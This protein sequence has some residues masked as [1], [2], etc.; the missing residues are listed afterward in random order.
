MKLFTSSLLLGVV[1]S[2]ALARTPLPTDVAELVRQLGSE[3][4]QE[5]EKASRL[6][7]ALPVD[8]PPPELLAALKSSEPEVRDRATKAVQAIR[9]RAVEKQLPRGQ[10]FAKR[11]EID[12]FVA[13]TATWDLKANDERLWLPPFEIG[14]KVVVKADMVG[15][16]NGC[17]VWFK[18][19]PTYRSLHNPR[20]VRTDGLYSRPSRDA[21]DKAIFICPEAI[22]A[23]G[24]ADPWALSALAVV[25]GSVGAKT[26]ISQSLLLTTGDVTS[27][28]DIHRTIV[29]CDG[30]V[31][32]TGNVGKCLIIARG[33]ITVG[34]FADA[35][36]LISGGPITITKPLEQV[37]KGFENVVN[38]KESNP[39]GFITFFELRRIGLDVKAADGAVRVAALTAGN[40]CEKAGLKVGDAIVEVNG[41]K[42]TDA[43]SLRRLLRDAL[44]V[45]EATVKLQRGKDTITAKLSLPD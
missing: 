40:V 2:L 14:V 39:L 45:G 31:N 10:G 37:T 9:T 11:G 15:K 33:K 12:L 44:A 43:E 26:G 23:D 25:R 38:E 3:D 4:F 34:G 6:L 17:P 32:A 35:S 30:D 19:F 21:A 41:K 8:T 42:P 18:D 5:R 36:T 27:R 7:A 20:L 22:Q 16:I 29:I 28:D 24:V 1:C 13:A